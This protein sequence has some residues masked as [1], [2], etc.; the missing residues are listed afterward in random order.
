VVC[1]ICPH[2]YYCFW[3]CWC[4]C[5]CEERMHT[6]S[7]FGQGPRK[8]PSLTKPYVTQLCIIAALPTTAI[9]T[10]CC[11]DW[12]AVLSSSCHERGYSQMTTASICCSTSSPK[13]ISAA[14]A[15]SINGY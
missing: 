12:H 14:A 2:P 8:N 10:G 3:C 1:G 4:C 5:L 7:R 13:P 11:R 9:M 15:A 6:A